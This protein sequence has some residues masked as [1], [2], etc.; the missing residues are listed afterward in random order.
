MIRVLLV[1]DSPLVLHVL[2]SLLSRSPEIQV[3][4]TAANGKQ[5]LDLVPALNPDVICTDLHM[6]VMD[7]LEFTRAVMDRYP[8]P[9][10]VVSVSVEADSPNV[11]KLLEAGAVDVFPK[12]SAIQDSDLDQIANELSRKI[13]ILSGVKVFRR[14]KGMKSP[15]IASPPIIPSRRQSPPRIV[16]IG[17]S[18]GGPQALREILS[19]LPSSFPLPVMCVQHIGASFLTGMV[20]W[21]DDACQLTVRKACQGETPRHGIVYFAPEN[22]HLELDGG[23]RFSLS[24]KPP[25]DGHRPSVTV[26]MQ[27][28]AH[29]FGAGTVGVLLTGMGRDGADGMA[30]IA[31]AGG[32]TFAQNETSSVVYGMPKEAVALGAVQHILSLEQIAPALDELVNPMR[33]VDGG[34]RNKPNAES[35]MRGVE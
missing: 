1:D 14:N 12:P 9:I 17:A 32:I 33:S 26:T 22:T 5:A 24:I 2:Q 4:G 35:G 11:F 15:T 18:T 31:A 10:L 29:Y 8:R 25:L 13:R 19:H 28:A 16:V 3:V 27:A 6:P 30:S 21:L 34:M 20:E 7:G 23:G